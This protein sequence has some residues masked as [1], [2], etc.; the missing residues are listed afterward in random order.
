MEQKEQLQQA[1]KDRMDPLINHGLYEIVDYH[2]QQTSQQIETDDDYDVDGYRIKYSFSSR[3][4]VYALLR[5]TKKCGNLE[6]VVKGGSETVVEETELPEL[7][8]GL[9]AR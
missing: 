9:I 8:P 6:V 7:T 1:I 2:V 4:H 5:H 3:Y